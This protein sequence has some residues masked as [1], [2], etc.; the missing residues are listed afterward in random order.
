MKTFPLPAVIAAFAGVIA[1]PFSAIGALTLLLTAGLGTI[2]HAD[3]ALRCR[4]VRLPRR[5]A[6]RRAAPAR[7]TLCCETHRLAA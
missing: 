3:Y 1:L 5:T 4:R 7:P 2:I 6:L